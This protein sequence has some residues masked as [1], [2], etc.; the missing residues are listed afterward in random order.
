MSPGGNNVQLH[1]FFGLKGYIVLLYVL[2]SELVS[3]IY[4][5][6]CMWVLY[7]IGG[8]RDGLQTLY[9]NHSGRTWDA[10]TANGVPARLRWG[11]SHFENGVPLGYQYGVP[12]HVGDQ[13]MWGNRNRLFNHLTMTNLNK[14][15]EVQCVIFY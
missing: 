11:T 4:C 14:V 5:V 10:G 1:V 15:F 12:V 9:S 7:C 6:L 3:S 8:F 13:C 2:M